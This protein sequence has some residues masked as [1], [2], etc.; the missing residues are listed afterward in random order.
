MTAS[1][2]KDTL[3]SINKNDVELLNK[4]MLSEN[5]Y[6]SMYDV[7][8]NKIKFFETKIKTLQGVVLYDS[9]IMKNLQDNVYL[10]EYD[11]SVAKE[12]ADR[13]YSER[14]EA[15]IKAYEWKQRAIL[16]IPISLAGGFLIA[17][18]IQH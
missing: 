3:I 12:S 5:F 13:S 17:T 14:S 4:V 7:N 8:D 18:L 9:L 11:L 15:V 16:G 10:L 1:T 2:S 6:R